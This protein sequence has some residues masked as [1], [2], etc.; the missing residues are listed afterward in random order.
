MPA[1]D[2]NDSLFDAC[3]ERSI[4]RVV[5]LL[6]NGA[7]TEEKNETEV[8]GLLTPLQLAVF[9]GEL[10]IAE[11]LIINGADMS[12]LYDNGESLLIRV[13]RKITRQ[14]Y[15]MADLLIRKG[16]DVGYTHTAT[17][18]P[19]DGSCITNI[20][21]PGSKDWNALHVAAYCGRFE[22]VEVL[23][24]HG[25]DL[26]ALTSEGETAEDLALKDYILKR[27]F[28]GLHRSEVDQYTRNYGGWQGGNQQ[29]R[30]YLSFVRDYDDTVGLLREAE[31]QLAF[32][33]GH[34]HRL[35]EQSAL[36]RFS[37]DE[38]RMIQELSGS[39]LG[40]T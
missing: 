11:L 18:P 21:P 4:R 14:P 15:L 6:E 32:A 22:V 33:M 17:T 1:S 19:R 25:A 13:A 3:E 35:G 28:E 12:V 38:L 2:N 40:S 7:D 34:H 16:A 10:R 23:L 5:N 27:D 8:F 30:D 36:M 29:H 37:P 31:R 24:H 26:L 9:I 20:M 39:R